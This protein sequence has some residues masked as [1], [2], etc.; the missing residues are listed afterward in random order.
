MHVSDR[1]NGG[2]QGNDDDPFGLSGLGGSGTNGA[3]ASAP[4]A[5]AP[6]L[7]LLLE[8]HGC[9]VRGD[10]VHDGMQHIFRM[11]LTNRSG[12]V[13]SGFHVQFNKNSAGV[14]VPVGATLLQVEPL[15]PGQTGST[16]KVLETMP[17]KLD[18][19]Q[20]RMLQTALKWAELSDVSF[21]MLQVR[22][23]AVAG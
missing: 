8:A 16:S 10:I 9:V 21:V 6:Q 3:S 18:A 1:G 20:G 4:E 19:S 12:G 5:A 11:S 14:G 2:A 17:E 15:S 23:C 22:C 13:M 7:P